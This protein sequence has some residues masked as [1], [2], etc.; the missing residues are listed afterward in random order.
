MDLGWLNAP[1][2]E[3]ASAK[4][5]LKKD[6][7]HRIVPRMRSVIV[8]LNH[9]LMLW[10]LCLV[11]MTLGVRVDQGQDG[12]VEPQ[13]IRDIVV[14]MAI[15]VI[16]VCGTLVL[17]RWAGSPPSPRARMRIW[18]RDLTALANGF[19]P[20]PSG[21]VRFASLITGERPAAASSP[22]F[23]APGVEFGNLRAP[24]VNRREWHYLKVTLPAPL[25]HLILGATETGDLSRDLRVN[26]RSDQRMSVGGVF[27]RSFQ[28][29]VPDSYGPDA[30]FV[31]TPDVMAALIDHAWRY[32]IEI[33]G[34]TLIFFTS[35]VADFTD[36]DT[37]R[38]IESVLSLV[39]PA[40]QTRAEQYRDQ[41]IA[42]QRVSPTIA[43]IEA[44]IETPETPWVPPE[45][46]IGP[47]GRRLNMMDR[48]TGGAAQLRTFG[49]YVALL[50][51]YG[52]PGILAFAGFMST[53]DGH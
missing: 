44:A 29:Y 28:L 19:E 49:W 4:A 8:H 25:P 38:S 20:E 6:S 39:V 13:D 17:Y 34:D 3:V 9:A 40:L 43:A 14:T 31:L 22:R 45:P 21:R 7:G 15:F 52:V 27:D 18:R 30:F 23:H 41:R 37:W 1:E 10:Y 36:P 16:W 47:D 2:D 51:F 11:W 24:R 33:V 50:L 53:I 26:L 35:E 5:N 12:R 48:R 42:E 46:R 32:S